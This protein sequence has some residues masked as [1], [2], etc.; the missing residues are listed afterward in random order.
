[1]KAP[2]FFIARGLHFKARGLAFAALALCGLAIAPMAHA[3][4]PPKPGAPP[5]P[6]GP[7]ALEYD[8]AERLFR[9]NKFKEAAAAFTKFLEKYKMLSPRSL[10]AK[11]RLAVSDLQEGLYEEGIKHLRDLLDPKVKIDQAAREMAQLL[12]AKGITMKASKMPSDTQPQKDTQKK[13]MLEGIKEYDDFVKAF[14]K[15]RDMDSA[16]FLRSILLL[17]MESYDEA[18]KGFAVVV[19]ST[20]PSPYSWEALMWIGKTF[21]IQGSAMLQAKAGKEPSAD[22]VKKALALFD[23]AEPSL[24]QAYL[25]SGDLGLMNEATF[26]VGQLQLTRSQHVK[27]GDAEKDKKR[28]SDLLG[29]SLEAFRAVRSVEEIVEAQTAKITMLE[30]QITMLPAGTP[31]YLPMR[32]RIENQIA[33]EDDKRDKYKS[34]ADQYLAAR[35]AIA[36]IFLYLHKTDEA[37]TLMR[38]LLTR[39][40]LFE[41]DKDGQATLASLLCLTYAEQFAELNGKAKAADTEPTLRNTA[42]AAAPKLAAKALETYREFRKDFKGNAAGDNLAFLETGTGFGKNRGDQCPQMGFFNP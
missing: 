22:D 1:M 10:D 4:T 16:Q 24:T 15:S 23:N 9:G 19:R 26:F 27:T 20:P 25:K 14:P 33:Y 32:N 41:K 17:Q 29:A 39:P 28:Q 3:Q 37:R 18:M 34:G 42:Q 2:N 7:D 30:Q 36:R 12:V 38:N 5:A 13:V 35:L 40:E 8:V 6:S 21:F 11:F 31:D